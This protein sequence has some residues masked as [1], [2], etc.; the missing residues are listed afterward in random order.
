MAIKIQGNE[1]ITDNRDIR[2]NSITDEAGTGSPAFPN[3]IPGTLIN[4]AIITD[5]STFQINQSSGIFNNPS[6]LTYTP[7]S[8]NSTVTAYCFARASL[9]R[10]DNNSD[11]DTRGFIAVGSIN[12]SGTLVRF[13]NE[14]NTNMYGYS[15]L[16]GAVIERLH[17][18]HF[19]FGRNLSRNSNGN[20]EIGIF[21]DNTQDPGDVDFSISDINVSFMEF[22]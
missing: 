19:E 21:G 18:R 4:T 12:A 13:N 20:I 17:Y 5:T 11:N 8:T 10:F 3:G 15:N 14:Y 2:A 16:S 1:V 6:Q 22:E 7:I 9:R